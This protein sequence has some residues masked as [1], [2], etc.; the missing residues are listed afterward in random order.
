MMMP[1]IMVIGAATNMVLLISTSIC[2]CCTS[3]V[4]RV[5]NVGAPKWL[6]SSGR[7]GEHAL[8]SR[9]AY[10]TAEAHRRF[11]A[12]VGRPDGAADLYQRDGEHDRA[13][14]PDVGGVALGHALIDDRRIQAGQQQRSHGAGERQDQQAHDRALVAS[15]VG[16]EQADQHDARSP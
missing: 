4:L 15:E 10:V 7:E 5:I 1:P 14:T 2:T 16:T 11:G 12:Q 13:G 6:S 8:E 3:L 9:R